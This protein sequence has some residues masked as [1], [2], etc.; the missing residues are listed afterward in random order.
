MT[1]FEHMESIGQMNIFEFLEVPLSLGR[2]NAF[3]TADKV[4]IRFYIDEL[5]YIEHCH[6]QLLGRGSRIPL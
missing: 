2:N 5:S 6:P 1:H 4:R 3:I